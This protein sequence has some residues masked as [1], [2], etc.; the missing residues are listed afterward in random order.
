MITADGGL[1][2]T[3]RPEEVTW[4]RFLQASR[5]TNSIGGGWNS[6][7][8]WKEGLRSLGCEAAKFISD[9]TR[10][11]LATKK[12]PIPRE[13]KFMFDRDLLKERGHLINKP[14]SLRK[15]DDLV[16][17]SENEINAK[18][19]YDNTHGLWRECI[20]YEIPLAAESEGQ[21]KMDIFA[22]GK[23]QNSLVIIELKQ[24]KNTGDSPMMALTEAICYGIQAIRCR[25]FLLKD[26]DLKKKAVSAEQFKR[27]RLILGAPEKYWKDWKWDDSLVAPMENIVAQVN[28]VLAA[29][30]AILLFDKES[31]CY[32]EQF[33]PLH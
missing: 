33:L 15:A 13:S 27:I 19:I 32:L 18:L 29:K 28:E 22:I 11:S 14:R 23:D 30:N 31:I 16:E 12:P 1:T 20:G 6:K 4:F 2:I 25:D 24:A 17:M 10:K 3:I 21:L 9:W 7:S 26:P 8:N 5:T